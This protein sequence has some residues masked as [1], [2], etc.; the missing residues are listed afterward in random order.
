[1]RAMVTNNPSDCAALL[2]CRLNFDPLASATG[3]LIDVAGAMKS[4]LGLST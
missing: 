4:E 1:M 3:T 2:T